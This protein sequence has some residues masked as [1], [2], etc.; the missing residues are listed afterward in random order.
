M[1]K[2]ILYTCAFAAAVGFMGGCETEKGYLIADETAGYSIDSLLV[3]VTPPESSSQYQYG[4]PYFTTSV[5]GVEGTLPMTYSLYDVTT[6]NGDAHAMKEQMEVQAGI[7]TI[8]IPVDHT[9]PAGDYWISLS[10]EN[11]YGVLILEDIVKIVVK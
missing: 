3:Y 9:I 1:L 6:E 11:C 7:G 8:V 10:V 2:K 4:N 5:E